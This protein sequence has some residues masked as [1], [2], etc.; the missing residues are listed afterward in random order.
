MKMEMIVFTL[1][2]VHV[3]Y[4]KIP[5]RA[6]ESPSD[7]EGHFTRALGVVDYSAS[8]SPNVD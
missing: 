3:I 2:G 5:R 1:R 6:E 4:A 8:H 7:R